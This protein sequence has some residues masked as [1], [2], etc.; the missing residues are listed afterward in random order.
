MSWLLEDVEA[1]VCVVLVEE[2]V[3]VWGTVLVLPVEGDGAVVGAGAAAGV[4]VV[5]V[6]GL[7]L[8]G[9]AWG[10]VAC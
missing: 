9:T 1:P 6:V 5:V 7:V 10:A 3:A 4:L 8:C 2:P